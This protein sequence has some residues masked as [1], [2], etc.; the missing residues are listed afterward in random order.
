[1]GAKYPDVRADLGVYALGQ[2]AIIGL[3]TLQAVL[4]RRPADHLLTK[5]PLA[6]RRNRA[7]SH[8]PSPDAARHN[9]QQPRERLGSPHAYLQV[10]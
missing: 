3:R 9:S 7:P 6:E 10:R 1:M 4:R 2:L 8:D 5:R